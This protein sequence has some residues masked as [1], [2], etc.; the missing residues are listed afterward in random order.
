MIRQSRH[1][2]ALEFFSGIGLARA[3]MNTVGIETVW[4]NDIDNV[5]CRLY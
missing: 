3:G 2:R 4:A 1:L 5:K